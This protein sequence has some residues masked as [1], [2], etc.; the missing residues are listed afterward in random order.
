MGKGMSM[1]WLYTKYA[2]KSA[3]TAQIKIF[4]KAQ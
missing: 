3:R 2:D 4:R 1:E